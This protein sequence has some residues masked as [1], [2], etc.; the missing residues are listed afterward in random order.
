MQVIKATMV[1]LAFGISL[2]GMPASQASDDQTKD[3]DRNAIMEEITAPPAQV[4]NSADNQPK[5]ID[6]PVKPQ[7]LETGG[8]VNGQN[9]NAFME[10]VTPGRQAAPPPKREWKTQD[11]SNVGVATDQRGHIIPRILPNGPAVLPAGTSS[12]QSFNEVPALTGPNVING[13]PVGG[14]GTT[15]VPTGPMMSV[16]NP[17]YQSP[18]VG[19]R[20]GP[21]N[22]N[23]GMPYP[24]GY[25]PPANVMVPVAPNS[26]TTFSSPFG[27]STVTNTTRTFGPSST[28][29]FPIPGQ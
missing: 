25:A 7:P 16:P 2:G 13:I 9:G 6:P 21:I 8:V 19:L 15:Y 1:V 4:R 28:P 18:N 11:Y 10:E 27:S 5:E 26:T 22:I 24:Y 14:T 3:N 17:Y 23:N 29:P 12:I 20:I